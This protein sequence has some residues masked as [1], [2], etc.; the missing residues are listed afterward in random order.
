MRTYLMRSKRLHRAAAVVALAGLGSLTLGMGPA[1]AETTPEQTATFD[2]GDLDASGTGEFDQFDPSLG[3]LTSISITAEVEMSFDVCVTNHSAESTVIPAGEA[4]GDAV[5]T[6]AGDIVA[7]VAGTMPVPELTLAEG[8]DTDDCTA[9]VE[10]GVVPASDDSELTSQSGVVDTFSTTIT[11]PAVLELYTGT[12]TVPFSY[13]PSSN[14]EIN[15]PSEWTIA[16][17]AA[18]AGEAT[19]QYEYDEE[20]PP[21]SSPP[22]DNNPPPDDPPSGGALPDTGGPGSWWLALA[23]ALIAA[24]G[25][26]LVVR[27]VRGSTS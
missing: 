17:L 14:A 16:F 6:F 25:G 10:E 27:H 22:P 3:T 13:E 1:A 12:G 9:F 4:T 19:I 2:L 8:D 18:G 26:A 5:L 11:D 24:G 20:G 23:G 21:P 15:Q 7:D